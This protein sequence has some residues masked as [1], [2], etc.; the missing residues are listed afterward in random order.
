MKYLITDKK[1]VGGWAL[2]IKLGRKS[3]N[4]KEF[5]YNRA[6]LFL[7]FLINDQEKEASFVLS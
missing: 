7:Y 3:P 4:F 6:G 5:N 1:R 2:G